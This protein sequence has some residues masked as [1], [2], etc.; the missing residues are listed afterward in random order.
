MTE[1]ASPGPPRPEPVLPDPD[2]PGPE[3]TEGG[4]GTIF[5]ARPLPT[6]AE[7]AKR[8][9]VPP[10]EPVFDPEKDGG[11]GTTFES[12]EPLIAARAPVPAE[13]V[14]FTGGGGGTMPGPSRVTREMP[15]SPPPARVADGAGG[16]MLVASVAPPPFDSVRADPE[17]PS[18]ETLGGGGT[19]SCVPKSLPMMLLTNE[20]LLVCVG[21]GGIT[22][23]VERAA[24]P[25]SSLRNSR[26]ASAEGGGATTEGA[27]RLSFALRPRSCS[28]AETG[29]GTTAALFIWTREGETSRP[30][31]VGAG[32]IMPAASADAERVR[33]RETLVEAGAITFALNEDDVRERSRETSGAGATMLVL[34]EGAVIRCSD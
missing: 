24:L 21:G 14:A 16:M 3:P 26:A 29:G 34:S 13:P 15:E 7:F 23:A 31:A 9:P 2:R 12:R 5:D 20:P 8:P 19:T 18:G 33:S 27:G 6:L 17:V 11:G 4:G 30:T 28:G 32:G 25:L 10:P 1:P 22:T